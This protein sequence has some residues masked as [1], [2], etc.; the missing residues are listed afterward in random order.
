MSRMSTWMGKFAL[1]AVLFSL[2]SWGIIITQAPPCAAQATEQLQAQPQPPAETKLAKLNEAALPVP[3]ATAADA[4]T[5][6][7]TAPSPAVRVADP[8]IPAAVAKELEIMKVRIEQL[9]MELKSRAATTDAS[10]TAGTP[11]KAA[12]A[13]PAVAAQPQEAAAPVSNNTSAAKPEKPAPTEPFAYADWTWLNGTAR[14]KDAVWDSKFF[15]PEI[16]F[17]TDFVSSMNHP[18]DDSL[19]GSTEIFRSNEIQVEQISVGGDFHWQNVRGRILTMGGMFAT[20]T[21]RND[22]SVGRGQWDL[23]GAYKYFSEA[24]GG[25][26]INVNHGLNVDAGIFVSYI[27]LF[28]YYNFDN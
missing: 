1:P 14:N 23:T 11:A 22:G 24:Y 16:R 2:C 8:E 18:K 26:H 20:T 10:L 21:P 6:T 5:T 19:G 13:L 25:Y 9:E 12:V 17:D 28:S 27:G 4:G 7:T 3:V 15:T